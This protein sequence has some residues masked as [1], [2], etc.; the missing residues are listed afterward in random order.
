MFSR[1]IRDDLELHLTIPKF[2]SEIFRLV[3]A[4]RSYL[5]EWL[6]WL[7]ANTS[8]RDTR[9]HLEGRI[10]AFAKSGVVHCTIFHRNRIVGVA[11]YN[12]VDW[13]FR[14]GHIGYW[15][16]R[17]SMGKGIMTASVLELMHVGFR[18][19]GMLKAQIDIATG[20]ARS[21]SVAL[22]LGFREEG[23]LPKAEN[24]YGTYVD[25][26][27]YGMSREEFREK[28]PAGSGA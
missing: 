6:P 25:H 15:L 22:R 7:D 10:M 13:E 14:T 20:N 18:E 2:A 17:A 12:H 24:L 27:V 1:R 3:D 4:N 26:V 5:R 11:G 19:Q 21:R 8:E 9:A 23:V 28:F 16:E